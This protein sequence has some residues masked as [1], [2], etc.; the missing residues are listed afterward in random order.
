MLLNQNVSRNLF[1]IAILLFGH[2]GI[3]SSCSSDDNSASE[4]GMAPATHHHLWSGG[5]LRHRIEKRERLT[6]QR[7]RHSVRQTNIFATNLDKS[8]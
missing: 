4:P 3:F 7:D 1:L 5:L 2:A 8:K 6:S